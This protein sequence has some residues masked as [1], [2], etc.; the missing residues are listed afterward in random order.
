MGKAILSTSIGAEGLAV[1]D[2]ENIILED[3]PFEF[4]KKIIKLGKDSKMRAS[5]GKNASAYVRENCSWQ[6]VGE[7]FHLICCSDPANQKN[8]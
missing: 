2:G 1:K 4:R 5:L 3:D 7:V 8:S 6:H